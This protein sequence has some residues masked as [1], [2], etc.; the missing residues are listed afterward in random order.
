MFAMGNM[1]PDSVI[2]GS[3]NRNETKIACCWVL[4]RVEKNRLRPSV[5]K[6]KTS[7]A[8]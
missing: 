8:R 4:A 3:M 1:K 5:E 6:R 2:A 7:A